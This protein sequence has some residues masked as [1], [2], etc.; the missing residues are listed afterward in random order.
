M[1][2]LML[3]C[4]QTP[5]ELLAQPLD[6]TVP[7]EKVSIYWGRAQTWI[8]RN[9]HMKIQTAT[10]YVIETYTPLKSGQWGYS[11]TRTDQE[12]ETSILNF[13]AFGV[14]VTQIDT[15]V[16]AKALSW[17]VKHGKQIGN[18]IVSKAQFWLLDR[19]IEKE[20]GVKIVAEAPADCECKE[21]GYK[22]AKGRS[23]YL[24]WLRS[25]ENAKKAGATHVVYV[26][27]TTKTFAARA[28]V[29]ALKCVCPPEE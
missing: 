27:K 29:K 15:D 13:N 5:E 4:F 9:A 20:A 23:Q 19:H 7:T 14:N 21:L 22:N 17:F 6:I 1:L 11:V 16:N 2:I 3:I 24:A 25:A 18:E 8:H 10:D 12:D 26:S 28:T